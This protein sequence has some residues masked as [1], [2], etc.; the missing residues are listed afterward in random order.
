MTFLYRDHRALL[1]ESM[2]TVQTMRSWGELEGWVRDRSRRNGE[3]TV[4]PYGGMDKRINWDT[5]IVCIDGDAFGFTNA[6]VTP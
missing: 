3:V 1:E 2:Q 4:E 5:H 6:M